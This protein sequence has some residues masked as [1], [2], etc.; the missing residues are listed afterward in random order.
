[1]ALLNNRLAPITLTI[2]FFETRSDVAADAFIAW[3]EPIQRE[4]GVSLTRRHLH[5]VLDSV[6]RSLLPLTTVERRRFLF[7]SAK[8]N[9]TAFF[10]S[11]HH[12]TD[13]STYISKLL[14]CRAVRVTGVPH[15]FKTGSKGERGRWGATIFELIDPRAGLPYD[16][17][18]SVYAANDGGRWVFGCHGEVQSFER[19]VAYSAKRIRD[20]FTPAM[21]SD[22]LSAPGIFAFDESF[23][24]CES[25]GAELIEK[26]GPCAP[27]MVEVSLED[28]QM[29]FG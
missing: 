7:I 24:E 17:V 8:N 13:P 26:K 19:I 29:E 22:Y 16:R 3:Q 1:M 2:V 14:N 4:R 6:L 15:T 21:L 18:R 9:W 27:K 23:Y 25:I 12:G 11:G 5:G 28:V 10:D 20:R